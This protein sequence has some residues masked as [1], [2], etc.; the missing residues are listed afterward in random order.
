M[1]NRKYIFT[2]CLI[3]TIFFVS[4]SFIGQSSKLNKFRYT[5][6]ELL[7]ANLTMPKN[8]AYVPKRFDELR[9]ANFTNTDS[10]SK[11]LIIGDSYAQDLINAIFEVGYNKNIQLSTRHIP[12]ECGN[13][14]LSRETFVNNISLENRLG[15]CNGSGIYEDAKLKK[16]MLDADEVWFASAWQEWQVPLLSVSV[17]NTKRFTKK[18]VKVFGRKN[19]GHTNLR[20]LLDLPPGLRYRKLNE[21]PLWQT[22]INEDMRLSLGKEVFIDVQSLLCGDVAKYCVIFTD[23]KKL[24]TFDGTHL[25][26]YGARYYGQKLFDSGLLKSQTRYNSI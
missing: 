12:K 14:F 9:N 7:I 1:F 19:F 11:I 16:I 20:S 26:P 17:E 10:R 5:D 15:K 24:K 25:T 8:L 23:E 18:P 4:L 21:V 13:L 3:L 22:K 2:C 6:E